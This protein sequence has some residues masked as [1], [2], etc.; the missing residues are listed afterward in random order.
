MPSWCLEGSQ[1][2]AECS[3]SRPSQVRNQPRLPPSVQLLSLSVHLQSA[4]RLTGAHIATSEIHARSAA[5]QSRPW[6]PSLVVGQSSAPWVR[7]QAHSLSVPSQDCIPEFRFPRS[8]SKPVR[9]WHSSEPTRKD[10]NCFKI[11]A[12]WGDAPRLCLFNVKSA[13][14]N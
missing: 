11:S 2:S 6:C 9:T 1:A 4:A 7:N 13:S 10:T 3:H 8:Q 5:S 12:S 14:A